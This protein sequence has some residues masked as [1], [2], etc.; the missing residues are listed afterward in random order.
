[1]KQYKIHKKKNIQESKHINFNKSDIEKKNLTKFKQINLEIKNFRQ[2]VE[3]FFKK[4]EGILHT[5][6]YN[7]V[8]LISFKEGEVVLNTEKII[9]NNFNR[10]VAKLISKWT[11]RIWQIHSSKSNIGKSLHSEDIINQQKQIELMKNN[12]YVKKI[13]NEFPE[14]KIHS[15]TELTDANEIEEGVN[16]K[17]KKEK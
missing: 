11:G 4:K 13:L 9:D 2:F 10:N 16:N 6:L 15:I 5:K 14:S 3:M 1:M 12:V 7:D 17:L 8:T